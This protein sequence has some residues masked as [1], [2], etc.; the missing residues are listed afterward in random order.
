MLRTE[1]HLLEEFR[2][3]Q[4]GPLFV[5]VPRLARVSHISH[6][7]VNDGFRANKQ[8]IPLASSYKCL[9]IKIGFAYTKIS[10]SNH[11]TSGASV[12]V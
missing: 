7:Q 8:T 4:L 9:G 12:F 3:N 2:R 1:H 10:S 11:D 5:N 6:L